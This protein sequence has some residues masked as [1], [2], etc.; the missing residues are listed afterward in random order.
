MLIVILRR[1]PMTISS[2]EREAKK[3]KIAVD[4]NPVE[5]SFEKWACDLKKECDKKKISIN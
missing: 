1:N 3:V 5:T 2:P 4:R